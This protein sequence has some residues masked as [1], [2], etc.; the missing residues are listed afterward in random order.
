[1]SRF[2]R[3]VGLARSLAIYH[4]IPFRQQRLRRLYGAFVKRD[5]LVIDV[6]AH[7]GNHVR[8]LSALGCRVI[9]VEPQ[10][11]FVRLLELLFGRS[12]NVT[13]L[14]AGVGDRPG[15]ATLSIS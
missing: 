12:G 5:D 13:I 14:A 8:A 2:D 10:P 15:R 4:A 3:G 9:A 7:A 6:G 1:M 11:D